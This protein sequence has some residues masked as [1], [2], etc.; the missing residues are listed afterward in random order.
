MGDDLTRTVAD[1][2]AGRA[3]DW[4][5]AG[6]IPRSVI[7]ELAGQGLLCAEVD[8][9]Y[10]GLGLSSRDNGEYTAGVGAICSSL[11]SLMTSQGMAA[12]VIQRFGDQGQRREYLT[13]LAGGDTAA[14]AFSEAGAGSDLTSMRTRVTVEGDRAVVTGQKVWVTGAAYADLLVVVG[15]YG[16][17]GAAVVVPTTSPGVRVERIAQPLGCRAAGHAMVTLDEVV[18]PAANVLRGA[19]QPL[20]W[21]VTSALSYGRLSVAWGCVG[22]LRACLAAATGHARVREQFGKPLAQ[23]QLVAR[24]LAELFVAEQV[25][26]RMCEHASLCWDS[27]SLDLAAT[28]VAAKHVAA[29]GAARGAATAVQVLASA[30]A[31]DGSPTARAYRD[32]KL[33]EII[34][35]SNEI[36]QLLLAEHA[37]AV[38]P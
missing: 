14:V 33:M 10:G 1:L 36:S 2:V 28:V 27:N 37:L 17:G 30:G 25:A 35:G 34:E 6:E 31:V 3:D 23:H 26:T 22:I 21:L 11:R 15:R 8:V 4:D 38:T 24:H 29:R 7:R 16:D 18:L 13:R 12:W 20:S 5:R 9:A 19:G 32:A